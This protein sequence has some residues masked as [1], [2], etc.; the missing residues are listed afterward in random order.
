MLSVTM[1]SGYLYCARKLYLQYVLKFFEPAKEPMVL[2]SIRHDF[3]DQANRS[4]QG[5]VSAIKKGESYEDVLTRYKKAHAA[6]LRG[7]VR[8]YRDELKRFDV[9]AKDAFTRIWPHVMD[10]S[11]IRA[12]NTSDFIEKNK[13]YEEELWEKLTPKISSELSLSSESFNLRGKIDRVEIYP[14]NIIPIE[15]KTGSSPPEGAWPGHKIQLMA[16]MALISGQDCQ[17]KEVK[18]GRIIYLDSNKTV[19]IINN[20]FVIK[21]V[22]EMISK[23]DS[24]LKSKALPDYCGNDNKCRSCGLK[25]ACHDEKMLQERLKC[26]I[27]PNKSNAKDLNTT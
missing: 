24:V 11:D 3:Y 9:S 22:R 15:L 23:V 1:L 21:E 26:L 5:T 6:I 20:P 18:E 2:G 14:D 27:K 10:E 8:K 13:V 16:Y 12:R 17:D 25:E 7:L 4:E 19:S